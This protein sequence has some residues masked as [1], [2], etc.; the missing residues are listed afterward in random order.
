M[1]TTAI[2]SDMRTTYQ[3]QMD[4]PPGFLFFSA[5]IK[6]FYPLLFEIFIP[7][8]KSISGNAMAIAPHQLP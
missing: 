1:G 7:S 2:L 4:L 6:K 8:R 3:S 5:S